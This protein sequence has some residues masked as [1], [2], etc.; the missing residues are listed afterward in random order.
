MSQRNNTTTYNS[1]AVKLLHHNKIKNVESNLLSIKS[2][3]AKVDHTASSVS[4]HKALQ[5][6]KF[7]AG[8]AGGSAS[9]ILPKTAQSKFNLNID[10]IQQQNASLIA[11]ASYSNNSSALVNNFISGNF[12]KG[13]I[14]DEKE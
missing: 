3:N 1:N 11:S 4:S 2:N 6:R 12:S 10:Q 13:Q 9:I 8:V 7:S 5:F 14:M